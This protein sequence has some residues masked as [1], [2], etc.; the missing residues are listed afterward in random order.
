MS[1]AGKEKKEQAG[2]KRLLSPDKDNFPQQRI[3]LESLGQQYTYPS[4]VHWWPNPIGG[5]VGK[6]RLGPERG[7]VWWNQCPLN[8]NTLPG[9]DSPS[10]VNA[11]SLVQ[12]LVDP[13]WKLE[14]AAHNV[15]LP[16]ARVNM[17]KLPHGIQ[18]IP[19]WCCCI[20]GSYGGFGCPLL[21]V[22][23]YLSDKTAIMEGFLHIAFIHSSFLHIAS[24]AFICVFFI[25]LF[26]H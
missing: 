2:L 22:Q 11:A 4:Y 21:D 5:G 1:S 13:W 26:T 25:Y 6:F 8:P 9:P 3:C 10:Q 20:A 12:V 16:W 23:L 24:T 15:P 17:P 19:R 7:W 18:W 14:A